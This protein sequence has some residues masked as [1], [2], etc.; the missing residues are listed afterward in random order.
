M[1]D[2]EARLEA[3]LV[4]YLPGVAAI[5]RSAIKRLRGRFPACD[6]LVYDNYQALA[7]SISPDGKTGSAFIS[8]AL[9]PRWVTLFFLHGAGLSDPDGILA[10]SG[11]AVRS[12]RLA[13]AEDL[14]HPAIR[15]LVDAAE[16]AAIL[17]DPAREGRLVMKSMSA[18]QRPRRP[19]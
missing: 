16:A 1:E 7:V 17:P 12:L 13:R 19:E 2:A 18:R 5:G 15:A 10:G 11:A 9:Y 6:A 8:V 14:D 3:A 4:K